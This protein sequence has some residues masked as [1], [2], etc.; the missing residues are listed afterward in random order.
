MEERN[1][2]MD[3]LEEIRQRTEAATDGPWKRFDTPDYAEILGGKEAGFLPVALANEVHNADFIAHSREDMEYLLSEVTELTELLNAS[4][5]G[6]LTLQK[7]WEQDNDE[8]TARAEAAEAERD[9]A[10]EDMTAVLRRD[11]DDICAYC[12]N[13]IECKGEGCECFEQGKGGTSDG[14]E[15]PDFKWTCMDFDYGT[16]RM[17][18]NTPCNGCFEN[19]CSGFEWRGPQAGR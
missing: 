9:A 6:Q 17:M 5:A 12:K 14:K 16:C 8:L 11:S 4:K 10:V 7:A 1:G 3:R 15:Y 18:K 2:M 19:D 13:L